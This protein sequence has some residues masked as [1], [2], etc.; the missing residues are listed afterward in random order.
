MFFLQSLDP[1]SSAV[2]CSLNIPAHTKLLT[3]DMLGRFNIQVSNLNCVICD[4]KIENHQ[5]LT[6]HCRLSHLVDGVQR[7]VDKLQHLMDDS[8]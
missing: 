2:W 6:F 5:H 7:V 4:A 3:R 1:T 8:K